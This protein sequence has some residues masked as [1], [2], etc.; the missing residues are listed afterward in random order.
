MVEQEMIKTISDAMTAEDL[1]GAVSAFKGMCDPRA[2]VFLS[3]SIYSTKKSYA[4]MFVRPTGQYDGGAPYF[5]FDAPTWSGVFTAAYAWAATYDTVRRNA[6]VRRMALAVIEVT[7]E[8]GICTETLLRGKNFIAGEIVEFHE[9]AC[10]RASEM[11]ANAPFR[12]V[13]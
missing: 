11:C 8:H 1:A 6:T 2:V 10:V 5:S 7:D 13:F 12:V 3:V 4:S 9:A